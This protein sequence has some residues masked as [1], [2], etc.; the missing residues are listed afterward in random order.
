MSEEESLYDIYTFEKYD[1]K[2]QFINNARDTKTQNR[3]NRKKTYNKIFKFLFHENKFDE[4]AISNAININSQLIDDGNLETFPTKDHIEFSKIRCSTPI[5]YTMNKKKRWDIVRQLTSTLSL[6]KLEK[7]RDNNFCCSLT[8]RL[9]QGKFINKLIGK[10]GKASHKNYFKNGTNFKKAKGKRCSYLHDLMKKNVNEDGEK[11]D[12]MEIMYEIFNVDRKQKFG[13]EPN[14]FYDNRYNRG[15]KARILK[16]LLNKDVQHYNSEKGV[17]EMYDNECF[18][19]VYEQKIDTESN[20]V[21]YQGKPEKFTLS[22]F[23]VPS[24]NRKCRKRKS[25]RTTSK[26]EESPKKYVLYRPEYKLKIPKEN[27][28]V[29][30]TPKYLK[31]YITC[32]LPLSTTIEISDYLDD[33]VNVLDAQTDPPLYILD[34][35]PFIAKT[36]AS[37]GDLSKR[38]YLVRAL[39]VLSSH[40]KNDK[41]VISMIFCTNISCPRQLESME[42]EED[43]FKKCLDKIFENIRCWLGNGYFLNIFCLLPLLKIREQHKRKNPVTKLIAEELNIKQ[44]SITEQDLYIKIKKQYWEEKNLANKTVKIICKKPDFRNTICQI[45]CSE[46]NNSKMLALKCKHSFCIDCWR[47]HLRHNK[48][49]HCLEFECTEQPELPV[50][51]SL[52]NY[53]E[54]FS[55]ENR[56]ITLK[57]Y[58]N[59]VQCTAFNC[60]YLSLKN[61]KVQM[62]ECLCS[63]KTCLNC[64]NGFHWPSTCNQENVFAQHYQKVGS[65]DSN[66]GVIVHTRTCPRCRRKFEK[67]GGCN[68]MSCYCG[69]QFCWACGV[70]LSCHTT[71]VSK[72]LDK[73]FIFHHSFNIEKLFNIVDEYQ[74]SLNTKQLKITP[75][76]SKLFNIYKDQMNG[77]VSQKQMKLQHLLKSVHVSC[78]KA[79][80][81]LR[82]V[83]V[84]I[85]ITKDWKKLD[86]NVLEANP[87]KLRKLVLDTNSYVNGMKSQISIKGNEKVKIPFS[88]LLK[89]EHKLTIKL[90]EIIK[91]SQILKNVEDDFVR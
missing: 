69:A 13:Y 63:R 75:S 22:D 20:D 59:W 80:F 64:E 86:K 54:T 29:A 90:R 17:F 77:T 87:F 70:S 82:N 3:L 58:E 38:K 49:G 41:S 23:I 34:F 78:Q 6:E 28:D 47:N 91:L 37:H 45:C 72:E 67:N 74:K 76:F 42:I 24:K 85:G 14:S 19:D 2:V 10:I 71:C 46:T 89:F 18:S 35:S 88:A 51:F 53:N 68:N 56:R 31:T 12:E 1:R 32:Y 25:T 81:I 16:K 48:N 55:I 73:N 50:F 62:I 52:F 9:C 39:S 5:L 65:Y 4:K 11:E 21:I 40:P 26:R 27:E 60:K 7:M 66:F 43:N 79:Y 57:C 15:V 8:N 84:F 36:L 33:R 83:A 30:S 61:E 44:R